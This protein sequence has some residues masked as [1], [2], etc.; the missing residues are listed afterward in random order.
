LVVI[1]TPGLNAVGVEPELTLGLLNQV[2][3]VVFILAADLG[4]SQSDLD[5]WQDH[6]LPPSES[7]H[8]RLAVLNK[9]DIL[10]DDLTSE[11]DIQKQLVDQQAS[12][13]LRL[14]LHADQIA[15]VSAQKGLVA[16]IKNDEALLSKSQ[17]LTFESR[18]AHE[19]VRQHQSGLQRQVSSA[20][21]YALD[22]ATMQ[23]DARQHLLA[24]QIRELQA[25]RGQ[26]QDMIAQMRQR[27]EL[28]RLQFNEGCQQVQAIRLVQTRLCHGM[29]ALVSE[30]SIGQALHALDRQLAQ[31]GMKWKG[32]KAFQA[33]F[34]ALKTPLFKL[35]QQSLE[36][37][38][39]MC[40]LGVG[41]KDKLGFQI[42]PSARVD[43]A[44]AIHALEVI[45]A[46][47]DRFFSM[48]HWWRM[49]QPGE[50]GR[51]IEG[52]KQRLLPVF[53]WLQKD[54]ENWNQ[55]LLDPLDQQIFE[56]Q[57]FFERR[58]EVIERIELAAESV[59]DKLCQVE[60]SLAAVELALTEMDAVERV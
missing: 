12:V 56:R 50:R 16:R 43:S 17:L 10:W 9:I 28:E 44:A 60:Q 22:T 40:H 36:A 26:N 31:T 24:Q 37:T 42:Q 46:D 57:R 21:A 33:W 47:L 32:Q 41:L 53:E 51:W 29:L 20:I 13:A 30:G 23:L 55:A 5:I 15:L 11:E 45:Q 1:D 2:D 35:Q 49:S 14:G 34:D 52:V 19:V 18:M 6:L 4:V 7:E 8:N 38:Q 3:A 39:G 48:K 25:M 59:E 54:I 58:A 27:L